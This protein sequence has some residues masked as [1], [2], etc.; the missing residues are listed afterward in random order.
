MLLSVTLN[1]SV[2]HALFLSELKVGDTNRVTR[3]ER[4][5]GGKG[6]NL[7]RV[8]AEMGGETIASGFLGGGTGAYVRGVLEAQGVRHNFVETAGET[9]LNFS[10]EDES[11]GKPTTFNERGPQISPEEWDALLAK[12]DMLAGGCEWATI[13]G[14]L[15]PGV[16]GDAYRIL[17]ERLRGHRCK[18]LLDADG[19][20]L[21]EGLAGRPTMIKPND[22][23]ASRLLNRKVES[24]EEAIGAARSLYEMLGR[25]EAIAVL[26]RGAAGAVMTLASGTYVG[27]SPKVEARSTIGSGDSLLGAM[28]WS[29]TRGDAPEAALRWGLAAGAATALTDGSEIARR[30]V[31]ERLYA[32]ASVARLQI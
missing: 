10:V 20:P 4:D 19:N 29:L 28:L 13:G 9:R 23:E 5:A 6:V 24:D 32:D 1:P 21:R 3:T 16:P 7:S 22:P 25:G 31:V 30:Q 17:G 18:V 11:R 27:R 26:S 12:V 2:D 15:P 14:S 8:F